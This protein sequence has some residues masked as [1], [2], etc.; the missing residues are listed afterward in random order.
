MGVKKGEQDNLKDKVK[1]NLGKIVT[2][3]ITKNTQMATRKYF[4]DKGYLNTKVKITTIPDSTRNNAT[5]RVLVDKGQKVKIAKINFEGHH[6]VDESAVRMKMKS[7]KQ[8]RFGR[9]FSP[10]KFV[11]EEIRRR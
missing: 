2:N 1:L 9:L 10:S 8:Q 3:T 7:T 4:V 5:M 6:E 11:P